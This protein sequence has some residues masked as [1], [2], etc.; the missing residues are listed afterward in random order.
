MHI[1][2]NE[3]IY[4]DLAKWVKLHPRQ[5][6]ENNYIESDNQNVVQVF[7]AFK[8]NNRAITKTVNDFYSTLN[9]VAILYYFMDRSD[10]QLHKKNNKKKQLKKKLIYC[11]DS[12]PI[13]NDG[14]GYE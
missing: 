6:Q 8:F 5:T 13:S 10:L 4:K 2:R 11:D 12:G 1:A 7:T 3:S 14:Y 9:I